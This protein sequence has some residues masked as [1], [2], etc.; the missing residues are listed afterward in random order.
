VIAITGRQRVLHAMMQ[1]LDKQALQ[2]LG[3]RALGGIDPCLRQQSAETGNFPRQLVLSWAHHVGSHA[4]LAPR[5]RT[6][7]D[8][9]MNLS[10]NPRRP[11]VGSTS[12]FAHTECAT[13]QEQRLKNTRGKVWSPRST[14]RQ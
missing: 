3:N 9:R 7:C 5:H 14:L 8:L 1:F 13:S 4:P 11:C 10:P 6:E 2:P 12:P